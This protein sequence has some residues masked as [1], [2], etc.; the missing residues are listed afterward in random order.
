MLA[1]IDDPGLQK[2]TESVLSKVTL[3]VPETVP[4]WRG[5]DGS[6]PAPS[7]GQSGLSPELSLIRRE[8]ALFR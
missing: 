4:I 3:V 7:R 6:N 1:R 2:A 5:T 8:A